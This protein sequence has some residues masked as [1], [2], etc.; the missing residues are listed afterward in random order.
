MMMKIGIWSM[1][2]ADA[3][4]PPSAREPVSPI[5]TL[6]GYT[7]NSRNPRSAPTT[8]QVIGSIPLF[9]PIATT[10]KNV[11]TKTVTLDARPSSP[12]VKFTPFTVPITTKNINGIASHPMFRYL[13]PL[14][15]IS[16]VSGTPANF[17]I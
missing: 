4:N 17:T 9:V 10:V 3:T 16:I 5:N 8:A 15:G 6:A 1:Y 12:S 13:P 7:L 14:K 2:A 11:A